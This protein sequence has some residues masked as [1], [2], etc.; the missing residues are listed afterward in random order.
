MAFYELTE[1]LVPFIF[2][3]QQCFKNQ[4]FNMNKGN[5]YI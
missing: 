5:L 1:V 4:A 3:L 2:L